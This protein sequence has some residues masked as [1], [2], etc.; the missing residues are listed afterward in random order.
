V[1]REKKGGGAGGFR[2]ITEEKVG[3]VGGVI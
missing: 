1:A 3:S 2:E